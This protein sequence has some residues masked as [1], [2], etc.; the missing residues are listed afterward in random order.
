MTNHDTVL[1]YFELATDD[2]LEAYFAQFTPDAL[3]EDEGDDHRGTEALRRWRTSVPDVVHDVV[4]VTVEDDVTV[5]RADI[6]GA[7]P[8]S[9]VRLTYRFTFDADGRIAALTIRP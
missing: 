4:D 3:V 5:A 9:P 8:G 2:D 6:S 1:R 7:F